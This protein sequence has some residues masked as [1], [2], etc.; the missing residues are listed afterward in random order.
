M[1]KETKNSSNKYFSDYCNKLTTSKLTTSKLT[2]SKLDIPKILARKSQLTIYIII[3]LVVILVLTILVLLMSRNIPEATETISGLEFSGIRHTISECIR[4]NVSNVVSLIASQ[5]GYLVL[6]ETEFIKQNIMTAFGFRDNKIYLPSKEITEKQLSEYINSI[7]IECYDIKIFESQG[8]V[9]SELGEIFSEV[10][11]TN[12]KILVYLTLNTRIER[13]ETSYDIDRLIIEIDTIYGRLYSSAEEVVKIIAKD[14]EFI[15]ITELAMLD[16]SVNV[17]PYDEKNFIYSINADDT[18]DNSLLFIFASQHITK[19]PP[20]F[21]IEKYYV[22]VEGNEYSIPFQ[23][24][25]PEDDVLEYW[26]NTSLFNIDNNGFATFTP[27]VPGVYNIRIY[28]RDT[29]YN[30]AYEDITIEVMRGR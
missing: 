12:D 5:G 15:S 8:Y 25:D 18:N 11:I 27:E 29:Y 20:Y 28:A 23:A 13:S 1:K 9:F 21:D 19:A 10:Q 26:E 2:H 22:L 4:N 30:E 16:F 14:P 7:A 24:I 6:P 17:L 3:G